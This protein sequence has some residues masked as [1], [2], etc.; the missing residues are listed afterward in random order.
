MLYYPNLGLIEY[1][2]AEYAYACYPELLK[3]AKYPTYKLD[4]FV[5]TWGNT[6][7]GFDAENVFSGQAF[8]DEYTTVVKMAWRTIDEEKK[9]HDVQDR[10]YGVFFGN[11]MAYMI[12]NPNK[13]FFKDLEKRSMKSQS[14]AKGA[15]Q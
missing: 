5:Q 4:V 6:A 9:I 10:I 1:K 15:Y 3:D 8:T 12:L 7:T 2:C 11:K 14:E 13:K